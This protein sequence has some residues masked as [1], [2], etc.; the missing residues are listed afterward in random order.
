[1]T[2]LSPSERIR[3]VVRHPFQNDLLYTAGVAFGKVVQHNLGPGAGN[4][5]DS[6]K[7]QPVV[8][9]Y[10]RY[11]GV[12]NEI[13]GATNEFLRPE[14][15]ALVVEFDHVLPDRVFEAAAAKFLV[16]VYWVF[17]LEFS[18]VRR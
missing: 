8:D 11:I 9:L 2:F 6:G 12:E 18:A 4:D 13:V 5:A 10:A 16:Q 1:M 17:S 7:K 15:D 14:G 3:T